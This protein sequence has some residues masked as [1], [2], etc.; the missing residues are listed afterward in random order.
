[1]P[2]CD[3]KAMNLRLAEI[4][5]QIAPG[6]HAV[7]AARS[8]WLASLRSPD[9]P[10]N[11]TLVPL[12]AKCSE[13]NPQENVWQFMRDNWL[14]NRDLQVLRPDRR[15][16]LRRMEQAHRS[17]LADHVHRDARM[18]LCVMISESWYYNVIRASMVIIFLLFRYQKWFAYEANVLIPYIG[19]DP[20]LSWMYP[21]FGPRG[22]TSRSGFSARYYSSAFGTRG[23]VFSGRSCRRSR[24][25]RRSR[26]SRSCRMDGTRWPGFPLWPEMFLSS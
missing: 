10:P 20:F 22:A 12:P 25:R 9:V 1:M 14:S 7:A 3:T 26:L 17:A 24:L 6:A 23:S 21:A 8:G 15:P 19:N 4:A 18:G 13:L 2:R 5:T 11:I 16:L